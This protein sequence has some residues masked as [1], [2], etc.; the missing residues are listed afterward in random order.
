MRSSATFSILSPS[1]SL[2]PPH[3]DLNQAKAS[4]AARIIAMLDERPLTVR[5][6]IDFI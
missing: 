3:A 2:S 4:L 1:Y 5:L 6:D